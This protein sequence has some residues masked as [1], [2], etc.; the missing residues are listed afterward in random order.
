MDTMD[1]T[2]METVTG[3]V[4]ITDTGMDTMRDPDTITPIVRIIMAIHIIMDPVT[5]S[6]LHLL[7]TIMEEWEIPTT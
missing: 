1:T 7:L 4:T 2:D 5:R 3:M 6:D